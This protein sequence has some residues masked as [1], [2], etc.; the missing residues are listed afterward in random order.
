[1]PRI[2]FINDKTGTFQEVHGSDSRLNVS[3]RADSRA[4]YNSR[5]EGRCFTLPWTHLAGSDGEVGFYLQNTSLSRELVVSSVGINCDTVNTRFKLWFVTG[6]A[7]DGAVVTPTNLNRSS[8]NAAEANARESAAGTAISGLT[9]VDLIDFLH[10][11][12]SGHQ[13]FRLGDRVRLGQNDAIALEADENMAATADAG[14]VVF[15][16]YE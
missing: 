11:Q 2:Q 4:Y 3:A 15:F 10:L 12:A 16:Y 5:D 1:M 9:L 14:G 13:E 6:T 8:S 7:A